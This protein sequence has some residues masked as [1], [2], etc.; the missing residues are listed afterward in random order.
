MKSL[1]AFA[2]QLLGNL[3]I[4]TNLPKRGWSLLVQKMNIRK[5]ISLQTQHCKRIYTSYSSHE[6]IKQRLLQPCCQDVKV[7][8]YKHSFKNTYVIS[9]RFSSPNKKSFIFFPSKPKHSTSVELKRRNFSETIIVSS[10]NFCSCCLKVQ[11]REATGDEGFY[12]RLA[13]TNAR[14]LGWWNVSYVNLVNEV[15]PFSNVRSRNSV[16]LKTESRIKNDGNTDTAYL[17]QQ[18]AAA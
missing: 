3:Y 1:A 11:K 4:Y 10:V 7:G 6:P 8:T 14:V 16:W 17:L 5:L 2:H 18:D 15:F 9:C 13:L 12:S